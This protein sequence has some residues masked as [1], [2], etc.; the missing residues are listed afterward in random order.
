MRIRIG[1]SRRRRSPARSLGLAASMLIR[2][3]SLVLIGLGGLLIYQGASLLL[4]EHYGQ[5]EAQQQWQREQVAG[6]PASP[7]FPEGVL[8][9]MTIPRLGADLYVLPDASDETLRLGP[10]HL[11]NTPL[12]GLPGNAAIAGHR[13]T[14]F[15][16]LKDIKAGDEIR[17]DRA[18]KQTVFQ[19]KD[20]KIVRPTDVSVLNATAEPTLTLI[21]CYPFYYVG[22]APK[23]FIVRA[24]LAEPR[25]VTSPLVSRSAMKAKA[26]PEVQAAH[27]L[28]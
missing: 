28:N 2:V 9:R 18:G 5:Q 8:C 21:T 7:E 11:E 24:A 1:F 13:D 22:H 25:T 27:Q 16:I 17:I 12:P 3:F 15:R 6:E 26:N 23:R 14:H 19:V 4:D 10:G 20:T